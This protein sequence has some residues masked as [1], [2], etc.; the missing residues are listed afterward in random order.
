MKKN[1]LL[2]MVLVSSSLSLVGFGCGEAPETDVESVQGAWSEPN[3][4]VATADASFTGGVVPQYASPTTYSNPKCGKAV[5]VDLFRYSST[6]WG[7]PTGG[8]APELDGRTQINWNSSAP[9]TQS[10]CSAMWMGAILYRALPGTAW[11]EWDRIEKQG[12]SWVFDPLARKFICLTPALTF[13]STFVPD[14][15]VGLNYRMAVTARTENSS[16]AATRSVRINSFA[17]A[18]N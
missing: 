12:G 3:C 6:Y 18:H 10:A 4:T 1:T 14:F 9:T 7:A 15:S 2:G 16:S 17:P 11:T 13:H 8:A 5:V